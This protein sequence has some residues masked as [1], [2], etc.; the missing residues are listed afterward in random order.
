VSWLLRY[1]DRVLAATLEHVALVATALG[2]A[3][4]IALPLG[5]V[6]ARVGRLRT[7]ILGLLGVVYTIPSLA[8]FAMLIPVTGLGRPTAVTALVAYAQVI[9]VRNVVVGV[10]GVDPAVVEAGRAMGMGAWRL[11]RE[12][13]A[14]LALPV[15]LAGLRVAAVSTIGLATLAAWINAGGIGTLLFE[16]LYQ[17]HTA[18]ILV[19]TAVVSA[20]AVTADRL[21]HAAE[22]RARGWAT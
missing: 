3:L 22:R 6:L 10:T 2:L 16:G 11:F 8:L 4:A 13:V 1:P 5:L 18:K 20:L 12:I 21:L 7:P 9:L 19:G 14:P 15:V 17:D